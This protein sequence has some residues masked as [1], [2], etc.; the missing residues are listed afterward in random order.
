MTS[1]IMLNFLALRLKKWKIHKDTK[2]L[3]KWAPG[4]G[5]CSITN[6]MCMWIFMNINTSILFLMLEE[7]QTKNMISFI[8]ENSQSGWH[9]DKNMIEHYKILSIPVDGKVEQMIIDLVQK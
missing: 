3:V 7:S 9:C 4:I 6:L 1:L 8:T 5:A 2:N